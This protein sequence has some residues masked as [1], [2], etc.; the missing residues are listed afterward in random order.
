VNG[1]LKDVEASKV[2]EFER[3]YLDVMRGSHA[4]LLA[5]LRKAPPT[6]EQAAEIE[7]VAAEVAATLK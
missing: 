1:L 2:R 7:K 6:A 3:R 5:S 4:E